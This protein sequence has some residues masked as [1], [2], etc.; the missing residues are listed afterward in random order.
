MPTDAM[1]PAAQVRLGSG[2]CPHLLPVHMHVA[3]GF[4]WFVIEG[5]SALYVMRCFIQLRIIFMMVPTSG[6]P[7]IKCI[8]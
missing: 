3:F 2:A 7:F 8:C 6:H 4:A 5:P 1:G